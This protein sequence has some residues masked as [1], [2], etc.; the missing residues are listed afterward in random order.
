M[1]G[2]ARL[3][4]YLRELT[5]AWSATVDVGSFVRLATQTAF[6]HGR[7]ALKRGVSYDR[8]FTV[9]LEFDAHHEYSL[10]LR[11]F[12]GDLFVL[13]EILLSKIYYVPDDFLPPSGVH[14]IVDCGG[15]IGIT[16]L[17]LAARYP[18]ATI[19]SVEPHP[20]TYVMLQQNT[21]AEPRIVPIHAAVV[22]SPAT[23]ARITAR[24]PAWG[25][26]LTETGPSLEVPAITLCQLI[27]LY[28]IT[29]IDLL[30]VDIEG[31]EKF[32]FA[33]GE[34]LPYV[35]LGIIEL[36]DPYTREHLD[37]D[38]LRWDFS[39]KSPIPEQRL[40]MVTFAKRGSSSG[41]VD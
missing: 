30:K 41:S 4:S 2:S 26:K 32:V 1:I 29:N 6:F 5:F 28:K 33:Y 8:A 10:T 39:S 36:H 9:R 20:D 23:T 35:T 37:E 16:A 22:G 11:P 15:N 19:Y 3:A 25:N 34:F 13:Y 40:Q 17:Y 24:N 18:S 27:E 31:A 7:N 21:A 38:L 14:V 12:A